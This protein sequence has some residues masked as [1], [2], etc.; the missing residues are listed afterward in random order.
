MK[1]NRLKHYALLIA[2]LFCA[3]IWGQKFETHKVKEGETLE[4]I[5]KLYRVTP[6]NILK[7]NKEIK[8]GQ[9]LIPNTIVVVPLDGEAIASLTD[10]ITEKI[11]EEQEEPIGFTKHK[12]RKKETIFGISQRY[13]ISEEDI[14]KYNPDLYANPLA[15]GMRLKIPKYATP[16][17]EEEED[18]DFEDYVVQ[19]KETRWSVS[20]K[21]GITIDSL[22]ILNP[23]LP[24]NTDY[25]QE[26][27]TLK[28]PKLLGSSIEDQEVELYESYTVP[29]KIGFFRLEQE[30]GI[31][32]KEIIEL[33]PEILERGGLQEGMVLR[34]P[35]KKLTEK[36]INTENYIF[37]SVKPKENIFRITQNLKIEYK[38]LLALN[39]A[40]IDG[41][42]AGMVLKLPKERAVD[43][44][45]RNA[46]ILPKINLLDSIQTA[47]VPSVLFVLPFRLNRVNLS[48]RNLAKKAIDRSNA[49]KFSLGYYSGAL[50]AIDSIAALGISVNV[51]TVDNQL[52][53]ERT[54]QILRE[55][56]L[57]NLSAVFGPL[58]T[59]SL[60]EVAVQASGY[61]IPVIAPNASQSDYSFNNVF[62]TIPTDSVQRDKMLSYAKNKRI[63]EN[64]IIIA[65]SIHKPI[66]KHILEMFPMARTVDL[67]ENLS[68]DIEEFG[69]MLSEEHE[70]WVFVETDNFKMVSSVTSILNSSISETIKVRMFTTNKN[71]AFENDVISNTHLS[72]LQFT[73]PSP[74][75]AVGSPSFSRAYQQRF[76][77]LPDKYAI[78]GFDI[79]YDMLLKLAYK[80]DLFE[81]SQ[82]IGLTEYN[83][84]KFSY[85]KDGTLGY[86]NTACYLMQYDTMEIKEIKTN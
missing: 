7:A 60:S 9:A 53:L 11:V 24:K 40:L 70:N 1:I 51:R 25:L 30:Y 79:M 43:F 52:D 20:H 16:R 35:K 31:T 67:K 19:P 78:R 63:E 72:N 48:D 54:K 84:N 5:A 8:P 56:N 66:E 50:A 80:N 6:L 3:T 74:N 85:Q 39:P 61:N 75:K 32:S 15:K 41:L 36:E 62:F 45:V 23:N 58:D 38:E 33:N 77:A 65:D 4:S 12:V 71:R 21:Y 47:N 83:G 69:A 57:Q 73:Y 37:Y 81:A 26:G 49:I 55:E 2:L 13:N 59:N 22:L 68:V 27:Q 44:E 42:K 29:A 14:K 28:L 46:L 34:L 82:Y 18:L 10:R 76:G 86:F 64:I 17:V